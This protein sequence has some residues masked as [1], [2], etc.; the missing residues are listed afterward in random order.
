MLI[1]FA[2]CSGPGQLYREE[3]ALDQNWGRSVET[4]K[5]N[6]ILDPEAGKNLKPVEG[7]SGVAAGHTVDKYETSFKEKTVQQGVL[8]TTIGK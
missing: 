6:Q 3:T 7:L 1:L 8:T 4:A 5:F 2:G